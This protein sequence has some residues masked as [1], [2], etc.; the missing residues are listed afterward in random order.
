MIVL[1]ETIYTDTKNVTP[2]AYLVRPDD[3]RSTPALF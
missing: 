3:D 2:L 1:H